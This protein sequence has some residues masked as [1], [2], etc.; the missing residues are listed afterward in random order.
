MINAFPNTPWTS[1]IYH[2]IDPY[3]D[4]TP[5]YELICRTQ[6]AAPRVWD[7]VDSNPLSPPPLRV[8]SS[9]PSGGPHLFHQLRRGDFDDLLHRAVDQALLV[10]ACSA[11]GQLCGTERFGLTL[12]C[13]FCA[14]GSL[15]GR[16]D[17]QLAQ[18]PCARCPKM[19]PPG[20]TNMTK[21]RTVP[22][23]KRNHYVKPIYRSSFIYTM[24]RMARKHT[25][26]GGMF[27]VQSC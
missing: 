2:P 11:H 7:W 17:V 16:L 14:L 18:V 22:D 13:P 19:P 15:S 21:R 25:M 24:N 23:V 20:W 9:P 4:T 5:M 3:I 8:S 6:M 1:I 26:D 12:S 27:N 10:S